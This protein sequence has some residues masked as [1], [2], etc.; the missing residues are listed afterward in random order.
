MDIF[1]FSASAT[2][3]NPA[4]ETEGTVPTFPAE[5]RYSFIRNLKS[6]AII[7]LND[8]PIKSYVFK[9]SLNNIEIF[10]QDDNRQQQDTKRF[11][12]S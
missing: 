9:P 4:Q 6:N 1:I 2:A 5:S 11:Q 3:D 8:N 7:S 12:P 10:Q